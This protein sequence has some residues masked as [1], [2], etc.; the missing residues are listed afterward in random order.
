MADEVKDFLDREKI[1][2]CIARVARGEDRRDGDMIK[3]CYWPDASCDFGIFQGTFPE[4]LAWVVPG[5]PAVLLTQHFLGQ[6]VIEPGGDTARAETYVSSYH[7]VDAGAEH[8]DL[9]LYG[10]YLDT[11][12]KRGGEWRIMQRTMLYDWQQ[13]AGVSVDWSQGLMGTPFN[14]PH[15]TGRAHGDFS[16]KFF[17]KK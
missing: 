4:Y 6:S 14:G 15:F 12:Q 9:I 5:S 3:S 17:G 7:R 13:A 1:R 8:R 10:R 11:F 2:D 16:E